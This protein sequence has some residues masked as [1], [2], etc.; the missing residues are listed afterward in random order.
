VEALMAVYDKAHP[1]AHRKSHE[2]RVKS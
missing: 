1:R 2:L